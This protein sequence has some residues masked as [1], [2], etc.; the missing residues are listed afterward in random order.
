MTELG[1]VLVAAFW[2]YQATGA[3]IRAARG[4]NT[5]SVLAGVAFLGIALYTV[6]RVCA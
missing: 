1:M 2:A 3:F 5:N 4:E 6:V